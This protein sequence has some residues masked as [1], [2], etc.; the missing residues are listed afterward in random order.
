[1]PQTFDDETYRS[2]WTKDIWSTGNLKD[3]S[4]SLVNIDEDMINLVKVRDYKDEYIL[5][6]LQRDARIENP[7]FKLH[8]RSKQEAVIAWTRVEG[9]KIPSGYYLVTKEHYVGGSYPHW[10]P[11]TLNQLYVIKRMRRKG[12]G[13]RLLS[14]FISSDRSGKIWVES[15]KWETKNMLEKVGYS[16]TQEPYEIWQMREGLTLWVLKA[17]S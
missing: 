14:D 8:D 7:G 13:M 3:A 11:R 5:S 6:I 9:S 12:I 16:E 1:M 4:S 10:Y 2:I 15:P 17:R